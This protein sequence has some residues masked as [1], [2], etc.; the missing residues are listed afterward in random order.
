MRLDTAI[1]SGPQALLHLSYFIAAGISVIVGGSLFIRVVWHSRPS[2]NG[3]KVHGVDK[4]LLKFSAH[5]SNWSASEENSL[6]SVF[7]SG[8]F[9][10]SDL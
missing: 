4:I 1:E 7:L 2:S 5:L 8:T 10:E 9:V 6:H 3:L